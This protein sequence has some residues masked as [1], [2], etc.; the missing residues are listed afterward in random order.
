M[1]QFD[2]SKVL[3]GYVTLALFTFIFK[4]AGIFFFKLNQLKAFNI[5]RNVEAVKQ[6]NT[7]DTGLVGSAS[8]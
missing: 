8:F 6:H 2:I 3:T 7:T 5:F 4:A 1:S